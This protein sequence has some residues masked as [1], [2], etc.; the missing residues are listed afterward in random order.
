MFLRLVTLQN[1]PRLKFDVTNVARDRKWRFWVDVNTI[2]MPLK[3]FP[4]LVFLVADFTDGF[5]LGGCVH[6]VLVADQ[7]PLVAKFLSTE[8]TFP[9]IGNRRNLWMVTSLMSVQQFLSFE[10][11]GADLTDHGVVGQVVQVEV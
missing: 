6:G 7:H 4:A 8:L 11:L 10:V 2:L 3:D 9:R 5:G 1:F